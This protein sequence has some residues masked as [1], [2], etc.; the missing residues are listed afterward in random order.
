MLR[1]LLVF[2]L[3]ICV[4]VSTLAQVEFHSEIAE[5]KAIAVTDFHGLSL[6]FINTAEY[7]YLM[8]EEDKFCSYNIRISDDQDYEI[9]VCLFEDPEISEEF[10]YVHSSS[11]SPD[12]V[13]FHNGH[14]AGAPFSGQGISN[15]APGEYEL[16]VVHREHGYR[17]DYL[18]GKAAFTLD[19]GANAGEVK[20]YTETVAADYLN[21]YIDQSDEHRTISNFLYRTQR[22]KFCTDDF[23]PLDDNSITICIGGGECDLDLEI[24]VCVYE[25]PRTGAP[26]LDTTELA[27]F[28]VF[29]NGEVIRVLD[30][31]GISDLA[32]GDYDILV[33][34]GTYNRD[35]PIL[36]LGSVSFTIPEPRNA[37]D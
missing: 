26:F 9:R 28:I 7:L 24:R 30:Y 37:S 32:P 8:N 21:E 13:I 14:I 33:L 11:G 36:R 6:D 35:F 23:T 12:F 22:E 18:A 19:S 29:H 27:K 5:S 1:K 2:A 4:A 17:G 10:L 34:D 31:G 20:F 15:L 3:T 16:L 25:D